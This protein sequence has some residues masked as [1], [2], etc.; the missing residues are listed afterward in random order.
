M[1]V[2]AMPPIRSI[3]SRDRRARFEAPALLDSYGMDAGSA[4]Y[5]RCPR[6]LA[7]GVE[8]EA[9]MRRTPHSLLW[10]RPCKSAMDLTLQ[11]PRTG[12]CRR[13]RFRACA[14]VHSAGARPLLVDVFCRFR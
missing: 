8:Y 10:V 11:T 4:V 6:A 14:F 1:S 12:N 2:R 5:S 9:A 3:N 13:P 7:R